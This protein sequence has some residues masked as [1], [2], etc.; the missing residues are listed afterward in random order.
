MSV[1]GADRFA[2]WG[3]LP[4]RLLLAAVLLLLA[5]AAVTPIT[6]GNYELAKP[7]NLGVTGQGA[8]K[9]ERYDDLRLYDAVIARLQKGEHYY[10]VIAEEH[11]KLPFPL[12]PGLAVRLPTLAYLCAW[13]GK[14]GLI[15]ASFALFGAILAAWWRRLGEESGGLER[16]PLA[17]ALLLLGA[18]FVLTRY[19]HVLHELWAGGL[20]ALAFGLHRPG[21]WGAAL[22][23]AALALAI[24][25]TALPFVLLMAAMAAWRRDWRETAAWSTLAAVFLALW[26][27]HLQL[28]AAQ[29]RPGDPV[30]PSWLTLRGLS[31]LLS[32]YVL[33]NILR[34]LPHVLAGPLV[35]LAL[36]GWGGWKSAAGS[37]GT[38]LFLGYGLIFM[39]AGRPENWYWGALVSPA[40][41]IGLA[42]APGALATLL[43]S[44]R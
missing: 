14:G 17:I 16:R 37:F 31:G 39:I 5:L 22:A 8:I 10:D 9:P 24:R 43:R 35:V 1:V 23:A 42:F 33:S 41:F 40:V 20:L 25:E 19:F 27:L 28:I 30:S 12:T 32:A 18:S 38:F 2:H 7:A 13:L 36:L 29:L 44:A 15:A 11:R 34:F 3:R 6:F 26:A 4:A 21:R